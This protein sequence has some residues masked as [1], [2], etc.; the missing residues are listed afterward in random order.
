MSCYNRME[1]MS[2]HRIIE[3]DNLIALQNL[4][5][6]Y[7]GKIDV[8][9]I[10]PPY[11]TA[12]SYIGYQ[13]AGY[14]GGW[15][16]FMRPRMELA[17]RLLSPNGVMFIHIDENE[18]FALW[19]LCMEI[20]GCENL[21]SMIWKKTNEHF[22]KN[23]KEKPLES[24]IRRTH[25]FIITCFKDRNNTILNPI[26]QP[27]WDGI[28]YKETVR[29]LETVID[30]M[31]TNSSAKD[32]IA[33]LFGDRTVFATP[34][35]LKMIEELIRAASKKDS[36][37]LDFFAGSGTS[38]HATMKLNAE[39]GGHRRF[40]LITNNESDICRRVTVPRIMKAKEICRCNDDIQV[41]TL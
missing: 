7:E 39:D 12:I 28:E 1:E 20:F 23:R 29:P 2:L 38:G 10:D 8:M 5:P 33:E 25:E 41:V 3:S 36:I 11:N 32:E 13:D 9:P 40:I 21:V 6:A 16:E 4:I 31:G 30:G 15:I 18:F 27:V 24:G 14:Q 22:D 37:V 19:Q 17:Y 26:H 35:P 34:K